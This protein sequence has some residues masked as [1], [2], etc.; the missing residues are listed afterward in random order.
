[1]IS[2]R[3]HKMAL[4]RHLNFNTLSGLKIQQNVTRCLIM[5]ESF[6]KRYTKYLLSETQPLESIASD[7]SESLFHPF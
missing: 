7:T 5:C 6:H 4:C 1:M 2:I 3:K